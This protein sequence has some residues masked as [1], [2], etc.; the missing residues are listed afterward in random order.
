MTKLHA[1]LVVQP[2]SRAGFAR[3]ARDW[4]TEARAR[5]FPDLDRALS[6]A[7]PSAEPPEDDD[8]P[9]GP[10]GGVWARLLVRQQPQAVGGISTPYSQRAWRRTLDG[11]ERDRP[12]QVRLE[13][14]LLGPDGQPPGAGLAVLS[15]QRSQHDPRW[16]RFEAESPGG[17]AGSGAGSPDGAL[18]WAGFVREWAAA[19]GA[20]YGHV[21]DDAT[22]HGTALERAVL[23]VTAEPPAIPRCRDV[24]RGYSWVTIMARPL[25]ARLGGAGALTA[26]GCF[27]EVSVLPGGQ[28]FLRATPALAEYEGPAVR[29]VFGVLAPVL[30]PGRPD[31]EA[32]SGSRVRLVLDADAADVA[33]GVKP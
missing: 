12:F 28:V 23:G 27:T 16:A 25:A 17:S 15:V 24:L 1:E 29:R 18:A 2:G 3:L 9:W 10:P 7:G 11:L 19:A 5:L 6:T 32:V 4:L 8:A 14:T 13:M 22:S 31:P 26:S 30:L 20:H 33:G 21:T